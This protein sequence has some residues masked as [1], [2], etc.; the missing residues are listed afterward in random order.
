MEH[1]QMMEKSWS[2]IHELG[3]TDEREEYEKD[4][5]NHYLV[6]NIHAV[7]DAYCKDLEE[8]NEGDEERE[9]DLPGFFKRHG[10]KWE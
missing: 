2:F 3:I 4:P 8:S 1:E 9:E 10:I 7:R 5:D 6:E